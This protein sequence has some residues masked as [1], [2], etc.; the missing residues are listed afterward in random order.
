M[1]IADR[2]KSTWN[3]RGDRLASRYGI[4]PKVA[5]LKARSGSLGEAGNGPEESRVR[6][7]TGSQNSGLASGRARIGL[8]DALTTM[9]RMVRDGRRRGKIAAEGLLRSTQP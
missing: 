9:K 6:R 8:Y 7:Q 2:Q 1:N 3:V 4:D 5:L